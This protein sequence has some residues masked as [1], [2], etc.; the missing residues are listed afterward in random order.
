MPERATVFEACQVGL[1]SAPGVG[2][3]ASA[4][5]LDVTIEPRPVVPVREYRPA[6]GKFSTAATVGKEHTEASIEGVIGFNSITYLLQSLLKA[7]TSSGGGADK[8]WTFKPAAWSPDT[9]KTLTVEAGSGVRA[10]K[11]VYGIVTGLTFR[12][13]REE[14][15]LSGEMIGRGLQEGIALSGASD[16]AQVPVNPKK[17]DIYVG[18]A[19]GSLV[20]LNRCLEAEFSIRGRQSPLFCFDSTQDSFVATVERAPELSA[21]LVL[22]HDSEASAFMADLRAAAQKFCRILATGPALG[23]SAYS[24]QITFPFVFRESERGDQ[25]DVYGST[26]DLLPQYETAFASAVEIVVVNAQG[27]A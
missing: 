19:A 26:W 12:F 2:V 24:L 10:E 20:K 6:G 7:G 8:T 25:D 13:T 11:F 22:E 3:S 14:A 9:M 21:Q 27:G 1:E 16:V 23:G 4:R 5:L 18:A 15:A 17:V